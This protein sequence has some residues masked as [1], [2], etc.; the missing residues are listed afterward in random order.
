MTDSGLLV[1][2]AP[3]SAAVTVDE[4]RAQTRAR[5]AEALADLGPRFSAVEESDQEV[6]TP[7]GPIRIRVVRPTASDRR[8]SRA[9]VV[10]FHGGGWMMGDLDTHLAQA[11]RIAVL[12]DAVVVSVDYRL[13]PEH[14]FPAAFDD[15]AAATESVAGRLSDFGGGPDLV[16]AGDGSGAQLAASVALARR[17]VSAPLAAQVLFYPV[18]D[19][20]GRYVDPQVNAGYM[21][22]GTSHQRFGLTMEGMVTFAATYVDEADAGDW[23]VSPRRAVSFSGVAPAVVHTSTLDVLRTEGNFYA[24]DLR[25]ADVDVIAREYPSLNHSYFGVGGVAA[26]ADSAAAEAASDLATLLARR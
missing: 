22:R 23:R 7:A 16:V 3:G 4:A 1:R 25:A 17:D 26:V 9:T 14:R 12:A 8:N 5:S 19:V 10:Y 13:A 21:S 24:E 18:T 2:I 11:R 15:A 6:P 20:S